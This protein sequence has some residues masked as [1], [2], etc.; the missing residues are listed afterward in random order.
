MLS[1]MHALNYNIIVSSVNAKQPFC[2][3]KRSFKQNNAIFSWY[4][5]DGSTETSHS[6]SS[7]NTPGVCVCSSVEAVFFVRS[8][9][10]S[11]HRD[12][13]TQA[14]TEPALL[15]EKRLALQRRDENAAPSGS[16]SAHTDRYELLLLLRFLHAEE[17]R[18]A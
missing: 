13:H 4:W 2:S 18:V 14:L 17:G 1:N 8:S 9:T 10:L 7:G 16:D 5:Q 12:K 11:S 6:T 15:V 3:S